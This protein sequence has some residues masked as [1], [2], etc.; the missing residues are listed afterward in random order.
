MTPTLVRMLEVISLCLENLHARGYELADFEAKVFIP[1]ILEQ[2]GNGKD[3]ITQSFKQIME[4][5]SHLYNVKKYCG[6]LINSFKSKNAKTQALC[7]VELARVMEHDG[8]EVVG[9][10]NFSAVVKL[11]D[12]KDKDVRNGALDC[13]VAASMHL[14]DGLYNN[15][16]GE[17]STKS[18]DL[19]DAR[20]KVA[21]P[22]LRDPSPAHNPLVKESSRVR[23]RVVYSLV[24]MLY[25][26]VMI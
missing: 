7:L 10:K 15:F 23:E 6:M 21:K 9:S 2:S 25:I 13:M 4:T 17:I 22:G 3:R 16:V 14:G 12:S 24:L 8:V 26:Y 1:Y 19:A 18:K 11:I 5:L 20:I